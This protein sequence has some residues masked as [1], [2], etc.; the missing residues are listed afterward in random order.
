MIQ[1]YGSMLCKD[2]VMC[3]KQLDEAGV[4]YKYRDFG[5]DLLALKEFF[6]HARQQQSIC[7]GEKGGEDRHSLH[8]PGGW[9]RHTQL[10]R[11]F[12]MKTRSICCAFLQLIACPIPCG[13]WRHCRNCRN[14][15]NRRRFLQTHRH[16]RWAEKNRNPACR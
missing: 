7:A 1:I 3:R 6:S 5:K 16:C 11:I 14:C 9:L 13:L 2:C 12:I 10:E 15:Q 4:A 8:R